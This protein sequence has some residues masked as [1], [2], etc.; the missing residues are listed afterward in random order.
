MAI[1]S[2]QQDGQLR[3]LQLLAHY[4]AW[5]EAF[6]REHNAA[7]ARSRLLALRRKETNWTW[8]PL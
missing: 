7:V 3:R 4:R 8:L 2:K 5:Y 6:M 1:N